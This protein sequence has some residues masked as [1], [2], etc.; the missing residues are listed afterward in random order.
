MYISRLYLI[1]LSNTGVT[2]NYTTMSIKY[3]R[4]PDLPKELRLMVYE[5]IPITIRHNVYRNP[6]GHP[7]DPT[8]TSNI[9]VVIQSFLVSILRTCRFTYYE[10]K[11]HVSPKLHRLKNEPMR[12]IVD[13]W[14]IVVAMYPEHG[15]IFSDA[16]AFFVQG[17]RMPWPPDTFNIK[18]CEA[19]YPDPNLVMYSFPS[20]TPEHTH[21]M[22]FIND[23]VAHIR[24]RKPQY[25]VACLQ[26]HPTQSTAKT[27]GMMP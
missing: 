12:I 10:C 4:F 3:F 11:A 1:T 27:L 19:L 18:S 23:C 9:A 20:G 24:A 13:P 2:S 26:P 22:Q 15:P 17:P 16:T 7:D 14:S 21:V 5:R 6:T 8:I 25:I